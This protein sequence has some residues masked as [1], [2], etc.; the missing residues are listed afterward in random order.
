MG[1]CGNSKK[2]NSNKKE[3]EIIDI[4]D[5]GKYNI[6]NLIEGAEPIN[7]PIL[8]QKDY[9]TKNKK[10]ENNNKNNRNSKKNEVSIND[11]KMKNAP[12]P[13]IGRSN[14]EQSNFINKKN[15]NKDININK[16]HKNKDIEKNPEN[17]NNQYLNNIKKEDGKKEYSNLNDNPILEKG[18]NNINDDDPNEK[19]KS[20]KILNNFDIGKENNKK[21]FINT[22]EVQISERPD[23]NINDDD[24]NDKEKPQK[25]LN[26]FDIE[27][28]N[29]KTFININEVQILE[30]P[31]N[32]INNNDPN[33]KEKPQNTYNNFDIEKENNKKT[34]TNVGE[35]PILERP[36]N[37]INNDEPNDKEKSQN[38][39][40]NFDIEK[41]NNKN[42]FA[43]ASEAPILER[44]DNNINDDDA[45]D[46]N[47][48]YMEEG[49]NKKVFTKIYIT[50]KSIRKDININEYTPNNDNKKSQIIPNNVEIEKENNKKQFTNTGENPI[51]EKPDN[52]MNVFPLINKEKSQKSINNSI[53]NESN[54]NNFDI[55]KNYFF[56]CPL[57]LNVPYIEK[58]N[59]DLSKNDIL[60]IYICKC[61]LREKKNSV[62]LSDLIIEKEPKNECQRH[63]S[64]ELIYYCKTCKMKI[65]LDC[66]KYDHN[67]HEINNN[68]LMSEENENLLVTLMNK[69]KENFKGYD[70]FV[71]MYDEY[72]K[73]KSTNN[74]E[75]LNDNLNIINDKEF[76]NQINNDKVENE[77]INLKESQ[78]ND[79]Q[80]VFSKNI[81]ESG[82]ESEVKKKQS[83]NNQNFN[84]KNS[85]LDEIINKQN[86]NNDNQNL[87]I[88]NINN[89]NIEESQNFNNFRLFS[90]SVISRQRNAPNDYN[91]KLKNN[92]LNSIKEE[93]IENKNISINEKKN[94]INQEK[95]KLKYYY[96]SKTFKGHKERVISLI[97]LK[98]GYLASGSRD[99]SIMIWDLYKCEVIRKFNEIGQALCLLEYEPNKLLIGTSENNIGLWD[100]N[101]KEENSIF[102]FEKHSFWVNCLVKI[103]K[104]TFASASND[105]NIYVWDYYKRKFLFELNEHTDSIITLIK[106][107]DGRLCSGSA[108]L[109][110]KIWNLEKRQ[111]ELDLIGHKNWIMSLYQLKNGILLSSDDKS[112]I[113]WKNFS[114]FKSIKRKCVYRNLCQIDDNCLAGATKDNVIDLLDLNNYQTYG[115]LTGH[116]SNVICVIKL[117]DNRLASC[118]LDKTIKIWEQ[119]S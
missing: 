54:Y 3:P 37:N 68:Y 35:A 38:I 89:L 103:D 64:K 92:T 36:D 106:L 118:S 76:P 43:N 18:D 53:K 102:N 69:F 74:I 48:G 98:S 105:C 113:I 55:N 30:R 45:N 85:I 52:N 14:N 29:K 20:Q 13:R 39:Y 41:E 16:K 27:K 93:K 114:I 5:K 44:P 12:K 77:P 86:N 46:N 82:F 42:T 11:D 33:D 88:K 63:F 47:S 60:V 6:R 112:L 95:D 91:E 8:N 115:T 119:K 31:D 73:N 90:D 70:I 104:N 7:T 94:I 17:Q 9:V 32:N 78:S 101:K 49:I 67:S 50:P 10:K 61:E 65:C 83:V 2:V 108:D 81:F 58:L 34:F 62:S 28:D 40:N 19:E 56:G 117:K 23:N 107:N 80:I 79:K 26:N 116:H 99:G 72:I 111:C 100:L 75:E 57:C 71:K 4:E 109:T 24:P 15:Q 1:I 87:N 110:I 59:F 22:N 96:N 21:T 25:I 84:I 66:Y 97:Q 51:T